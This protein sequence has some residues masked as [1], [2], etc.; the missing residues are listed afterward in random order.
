[1]TAPGSH[2]VRTALAWR[3]TILAV[4]VAGLLLARL[5]LVT[6]SGAPVLL[7]G[8]AAIAGWLVITVIVIRRI[9]SLAGGERRMTPDVAMAVA[10][11]MAGYAV[12]GLVVLVLTMA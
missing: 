11:T 7:A 8:G 6:G 2:R 9:R 5:G 10:V 3:R 4:A 1:V 12:V